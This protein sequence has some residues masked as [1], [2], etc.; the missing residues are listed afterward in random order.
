MRKLLAILATVFGLRAQTQA[1]PEPIPLDFCRVAPEWTP[2]DVANMRN[3]LDSETGH[4]LISRGNGKHAFEAVKACSD[5]YHTE[6]NAMRAAGFGDCLIWLQSLASLQMIS[7]DAG[8]QAQNVSTDR[9]QSE[10]D[11]VG[12]L[13][14]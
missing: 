5:V 8:A 2:I 1:R 6:K 10:A 7:H 11:L 13:S 9:Q 14:P 12:R 3:F 4:K